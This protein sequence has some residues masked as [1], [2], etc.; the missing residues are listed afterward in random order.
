MQASLSNKVMPNA[1]AKGRKR[2]GTIGGVFTGKGLGGGQHFALNPVLRHRAFLDRQEGFAGISIED[3]HQSGLGDLDDDIMGL[4]VAPDCHK[5]RLGGKVIIPDIMMDGLEMPDDLARFTVKGRPRNWNSDYLRRG[6]RRN[7][8]GLGLDV[9]RKTSP[10]S[11][12]TEMVDQTLAWP[13]RSAESPAQ[14]DRAGSSGSRGTGLNRHEIS[15]V[16]AS[17]PWTVPCGASR[18]RLSLMAEPVTIT[19]PMTAG[20]DVT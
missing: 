10:R 20:A 11:A 18:R 8:P 3:K 13:T 19:S 9:G 5:A 15:P 12:S 6:H 2:L 1:S 16:R 14:L 7:S 4:A 17:N